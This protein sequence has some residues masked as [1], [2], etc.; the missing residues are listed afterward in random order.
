MISAL[1]S[2]TDVNTKSIGSLVGAGRF[3]AFQACA[4]VLTLMVL[5]L[6][7]LH[8]QAAPATPAATANQFQLRPEVKIPVG[9]L[10]Y[11][12]PGNLPAFYYYAL[13]ELHFIDAD[14]LMFAFNTP[15]LL[16]RDDNCPGSEAQRMVHVVVLQ[17]PSAHVLKQADWEL[18]DFMDFLWGLGNGK[19]LLR[20]CNRLESIG[21]DLDPQLLIEATG[22]VQDVS[23][24]P[25]R[26]LVVVQEKA[27]PHADNEDSAALPSMLEQETEAQRTNVNFIQ[28]NPLRII[29]RAEVPLPSAI[30]VTANGIFEVLEA[31][32]DQWV[33]NLQVFHAGERK[34][35][36]VHSLCAPVIRAI[37][38]NM[39]MATTCSKSDQRA[40]QGYDLQGSLL[41]QISLAPDQYYPRLI[42]IPNSTHFAIES[43]RL[44]HPRAAMD[45][46][47]KEDIDG[48]DIDIYDTLSGVRVA[49]F[50]T[51]PAY[52]GGSNV[53]FSPDGTRMA[54]LH[55]GAI[56]I[57]SLND[58]IKALPGTPH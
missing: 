19:L 11:L 8:G 2:E 22:T 57:Y 24:S 6:P 3:P 33:V 4:V 5:L 31:P 1:P 14:H 44:K 48:E 50:Q 40:F 55:D 25:D 37:T 13:V 42:P 18:Y 30:P 9:P 32:H 36:T 15:G 49:T 45:P 35:A 27:K 47:T 43:L 51:T 23:F 29:G 56:E 26:S 16:K 17:L 7:G 28:L 58:L 52:T 46:L 54:V 39:L 38:N 12:P 10:G 53:D 34:I 21:A 20:R 41:W